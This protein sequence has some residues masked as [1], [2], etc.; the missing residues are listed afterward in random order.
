[1]NHIELS[2][3]RLPPGFSAIV[4]AAGRSRRMGRQKSLL[5]LNDKTVLQQVLAAVVAAEP[6]QVFVVLGPDG[7]QLVDTLAGYQVSIVWN[8]ASESEMSDSLK[9][10]LPHLPA[11]GCGVMICLGDQPLITADTYRQLAQEYRCYPDK[12]VQPRTDGR[13]G[14]PVLLP[15]NLFQEIAD[16]PTLRDL[17]AAH[18]SKIRMIEVDD[19]GILLDMDT[20]EDYQKI[21]RLWASRRP[22]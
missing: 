5:P 8:R 12:I 11:D 2:M 1:M 3:N 4:L 22:C 19:Q 7:E 15:Q 21:H 16:R 6:G 20:P 17:L 14:H 13:R 18:R 9:T 10:V